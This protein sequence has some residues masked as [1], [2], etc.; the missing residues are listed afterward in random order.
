V[1]DAPAAITGIG[2]VTPVGVGAQTLYERWRDGVS[3]LEDGVG[4]CDDFDP[5]EMLTRKQMR[6]TERFV[7]LGLRACDEAALQAWGENLEVPYAPERVACILGVSLGGTQVLFDQ[8]QALERDGAD[9]VWPLTI[10]VTMP[11]ATPAV[12]AMRYGFRGESRSIASACASSAQAI[13][14]GL[15]MLRL[16]G[17]DTVIVGGCEACLSEFVLA[18]F[19]NAGALSRSGECRPFDRRRDGFV[20]AEG[21]GILILEDPEKAEARGAEVLGYVTGYGSTTDGHHITAPADDGL[22]CAEAIHQ[23]LRDAGR[24]PED[25]DYVNAHGTST[26][27]NDRAETTALK[28]ALGDHA[29]E[30]PVSA[31]KSVV[32]H[33]IGAAGAVEAITTLLSLRNRTAPPTVGLEEPD[34]DLDLNYVPGKAAPIEPSRNGNGNGHGHDRLVAISN[35]FAFGGHNATLTIEA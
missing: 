17:A 20:M 23:A 22:I 13:G 3:G 34:E 1:N 32:G 7:Q 29:F 31:P 9:A 11:N 4:I 8:Y 14:E 16:G 27:A 28:V 25:V 26:P 2:A 5:A 35:S 33:S 30:I 19:R 24:T 15:R 21:A 18:A 6:R 10:P 12:L